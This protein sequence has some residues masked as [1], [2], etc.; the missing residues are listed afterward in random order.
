MNS[1]WKRAASRYLN[2]IWYCPPTINIK[3]VVSKQ[4][5]WCLLPDSSVDSIEKNF[6]GF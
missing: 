1:S 3:I 4:H 6:L 2:V 5:W